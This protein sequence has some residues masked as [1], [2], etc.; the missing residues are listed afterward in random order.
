M[1]QMKFLIF[2]GDP[3]LEELMV[4]LGN[5]MDEMFEDFSIYL[6]GV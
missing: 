1:L 3:L 2:L 4:T 5:V 6:A